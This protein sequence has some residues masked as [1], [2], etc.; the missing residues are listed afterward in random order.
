MDV[1]HRDKE[2]KWILYYYIESA[3]LIP[4]GKYLSIITMSRVIWN[5][6]EE[7]LLLVLAMWHVPQEI[8][9]TTL[10]NRRAAL[11]GVLGGTVAGLRIHPPQ[12]ER[13]LSSVRGKLSWLR[14][15]HPE[16]WFDNGE[17]NP[18]AVVAYLYQP[19]Q[20]HSFVDFLL[21][22]DATGIGSITQVWRIFRLSCQFKT[23]IQSQLQI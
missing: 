1:P 3:G 4:G 5:F 13:T 12:Y 9:S 21:S 18:N 8:I 6:E 11:R 20:D 14:R 17:L 7:A 15:N 22:L 16:L 19:Q 2:N 23:K 10:T